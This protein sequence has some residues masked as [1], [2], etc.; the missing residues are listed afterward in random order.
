[1]PVVTWIGRIL[2]HVNAR[3]QLALPERPTLV[4][5]NGSRQ[6]L[7]DLPN[8]R[9]AS[10][11]KAGRSEIRGGWGN[12]HQRRRAAIA[13][14]VSAGKATCARC[15]EPIHPDA[16]WHLDHNDT[17]NGY[18]GVSHASCNLA[19][20]AN[21]ANGRRRPEPYVQRPT[22]RFT[23]GTANGSRWMKPAAHVGNDV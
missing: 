8:D 16:D 9:P 2:G 18:L 1:V 5:G 21:K 20:G 6:P 15:N 10:A 12:A 13:P 19:A 14:L 7:A 3:R 17:R 11:S 22:P 4:R 23:S